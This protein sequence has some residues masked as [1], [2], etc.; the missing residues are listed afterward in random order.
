M[1]CVCTFTSKLRVVYYKVFYALLFSSVGLILLRDTT[2]ADIDLP[3][4]VENPN[5]QSMVSYSETG[6][7]MC[8]QYTSLAKYI[9][10]AF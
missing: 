2:M 10:L 1:T 6:K 8:V 9:I 3:N 7:C 4:S 5:L